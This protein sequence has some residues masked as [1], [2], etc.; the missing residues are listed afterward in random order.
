ML[1]VHSVVFEAEKFNITSQ[2]IFLTR[3]NKLKDKSLKFN[4]LWT[5]LF[6]DTS[7][8]SEISIRFLVN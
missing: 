7:L 8:L 1:F 2:L 6:M 5:L 4:H 3:E